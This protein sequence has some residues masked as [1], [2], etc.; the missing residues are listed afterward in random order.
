MRRPDEPSQAWRQL[1]FTP[2]V[3]VS[4]KM[5]VGVVPGS[6]H[7]QCQVE[8]WDE[9]NGQ[10]IAMESWPSVGLDAADRVIRKAAAR[11]VELSLDY[12][13]PFP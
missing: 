2:P 4:V 11:A 7:V 8:A 6:D 1:T 12:V 13:P 5:R 3:A 10:L 9:T